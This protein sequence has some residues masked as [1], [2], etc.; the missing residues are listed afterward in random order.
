ML[1]SR[2]YPT[3]AIAAHKKMDDLFAESLRAQAKA[4]AR[5]APAPDN[6]EYLEQIDD[7]FNRLRSRIAASPMRTRQKGHNL[8]REYT[9]DHLG[10]FGVEAPQ[11]GARYVD[12]E[13]VTKHFNIP[14][15]IFGPGD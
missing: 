7:E 8:D 2:G 1:T 11:R 5:V 9:L 6:Q 13:A 3:D 10:A 12:R 14:D 4:R 15:S